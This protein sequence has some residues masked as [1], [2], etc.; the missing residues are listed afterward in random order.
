MK[1][2]WTEQPR[3]EHPVNMLQK[4]LTLGIEVPQVETLER[5]GWILSRG[6]KLTLTDNKRGKI[7]QRIKAVLK[8]E[9]LWGSSSCCNALWNVFKLLNS[10]LHWRLPRH[11]SEI[12][13]IPVAHKLSLHKNILLWIGGRKRLLCFSW[14]NHRKLKLTC[15]RWMHTYFAKQ[16]AW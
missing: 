14:Q 4:K 10:T 15:F 11:E 13:P 1:L 2:Y 9:I 5:K 12:Y 6:R 16:K 3:S 7:A 8:L